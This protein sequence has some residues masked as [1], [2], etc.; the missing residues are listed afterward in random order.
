MTMTESQE[1]KETLQMQ[2]CCATVFESKMYKQKKSEKISKMKKS[3]L[4]CITSHITVPEQHVPV[5][6][7]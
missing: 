7:S 3:S 2:K 1:Y 6:A 5:N 4:K